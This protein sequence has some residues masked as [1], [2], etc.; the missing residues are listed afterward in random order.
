MTLKR[1]KKFTIYLVIIISALFFLKQIIP[2]LKLDGY[3]GLAFNVLLLTDDTKYS[4]YLV[5]SIL[6][7][8]LEIVKINNKR[9]SC[10]GKSE[11]VYRTSFIKPII[12]E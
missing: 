10:K 2:I 1:I 11:I 7:N 8:Y 6:E 9:M 12:P 4:E 5:E 3:S